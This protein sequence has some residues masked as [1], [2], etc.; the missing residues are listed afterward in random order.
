M[1]S[2]SRSTTSD[3]MSIT[4]T[5]KILALPPEPPVTRKSKLIATFPYQTGKMRPPTPGPGSET[6]FSKY[7]TVELNQAKSS[8]LKEERRIF[9]QKLENDRLRK[10]LKESS[11]VIQIQAIV[12]GFLIRPRPERVRKVYYPPLKICCSTTNE[13]RLLQDELCSY[14]VSLGLKPIPGLSLEARSKHNKRKNEIEYAASLRIQ[15]FF[16]MILAILK[17]RRAA[18]Q[19]R[20][21]LCHKSAVMLQ[22]FFKYV[23]WKVKKLKKQDESREL[24]MIKLQS[25]YRR[26]RA[27]HR[28]VQPSLL[29]HSHILIGSLLDF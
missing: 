9:F 25:H 5:E 23:I 16:R 15:S 22:G 21:R 3:I 2:V 10:K 27:Y 6:Y 26:F 12:R 8:Q 19:A 17:V 4:T 7:Q 18:L 29:L 24:A 14:A 13:A 11:A 20:Q 28:S 1:V